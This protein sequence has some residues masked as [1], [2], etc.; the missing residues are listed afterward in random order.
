[1]E[2]IGAPSYI[3]IITPV[4]DHSFFLAQTPQVAGRVSPPKP[5]SSPRR[6]SGKRRTMPSLRA[7]PAQASTEEIYSATRWMK[8]AGNQ[9]KCTQ[10]WI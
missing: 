7:K 3:G 4:L 10:E 9:G 5:K 2:Y 1:M 6:E 8:R